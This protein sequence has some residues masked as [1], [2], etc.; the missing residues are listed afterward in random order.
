MQILTKW[1]DIIIPAIVFYIVGY[2]IVSR[3][4]VYE[5]FVKGAKDGLKSVWNM[6]PTLIG[7]M[8]AVG[9]LRNSGFL[10]FFA[11]LLQKPAQWIGMPK[12]VLPLTVVK[13]FSGS[14]ATSL[15]LDLFKNHGPD[16]Y[17]GILASLILS[18]TETVFYTLSVYVLAAKITKTRYTI[19]GALFAT[20]SGILASLVLALYH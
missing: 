14:A 7:L 17:I 5:H 18:S 19:A 15:L 2:G 8:T 20:C 12:E 9:V 3:T 4:A 16:S 10:D 6:M 1:S 13:L 11:N